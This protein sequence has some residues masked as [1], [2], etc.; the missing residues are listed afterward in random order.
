MRRSDTHIGKVTQLPHPSHAGEVVEHIVAGLSCRRITAYDISVD[1]DIILAGGGLA[2]GLIALRLAQLRPDV[3]VTIVESGAT[4]GGNHTWSSFARDLTPEQRVWT[5][6]LFEH[7]WDNYEVRFPRLQRRLDSGYGSATSERL[8]AEIA[9]LL[10]PDR[11]LTGTPVAALTPTSVTLADQRVLTAAAVIDGRG[12]G[13][14]KAL[15]LRWQKFLGLEVELAEP[16]GLTGPIIMDATVPQFDGYR[17]VYTL[18][19]GPTRVLIEDT[20]FSDG[21][22]LS[23]DLLRRHLA[24]YAVSQGWTITATH[25]ED[26]GILPLGIGGDINAFW[27]EG[28]AGVP[29]VGLR[30]GMFHPVTGYSFPDAVQIADLVAALPV[31]DAAAIYRAVRDHSVRV[32]KARGMYRLLNRMLFLAALPDERYRVLERFYEHDEALVGRFYAAKPVLRDWQKILSGKPPLP[33]IRA[34]MTLI[35][36]ELGKA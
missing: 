15:D 33:V 18:P 27:D 14:T 13:P 19:F 6:P 3:R 22:D 2:N 7:R 9:R 24:D 21:N 25:R 34:M 10:P 31:L 1:S 11:V 5:A 29:R 12:Q 8:A 17:F 4:V 26:F 32:W 23:P 16:H 36:Y 35:K 28:E 30:S 20:Y